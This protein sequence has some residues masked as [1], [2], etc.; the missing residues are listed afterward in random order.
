MTLDLFSFLESR[1]NSSLIWIFSSFHSLR[2]YS[3]LSFLFL[4]LLFLYLG[5]FSGLQCF[6][7]CILF[8]NILLL[9]SQLNVLL[10]NLS[11]LP[12]IFIHL[13]LQLLVL[14]SLKL[15]LQLL[16]LFSSFYSI[17]NYLGLDILLLLLLFHELPL[18]L[19]H[20]SD[21]LLLIIFIFFLLL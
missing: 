17:L 15:F 19:V 7:N 5:N 2:L 16:F 9:F 18:N 12:L 14:F 13:S 10:N 21:Q 6:L 20:G 4:L 3:L 1:R 8:L 11:S